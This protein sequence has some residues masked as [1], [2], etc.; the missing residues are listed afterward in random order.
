[1]GT[2]RRDD[3]R[4]EQQKAIARYIVRNGGDVVGIGDTRMGNEANVMAKYT[5]YEMR[6]LQQELHAGGRLDGPAMPF[7]Y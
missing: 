3:R 1:M 6:Q 4:I 5:N 7:H 2:E